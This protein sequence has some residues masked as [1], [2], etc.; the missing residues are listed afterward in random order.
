MSVTFAQARDQILAL[1]T[2]AW[3]AHNDYPLLFDD[4]A[5]EEIPKTSTPWAR[6][7][8]R[9][10]SGEQDTLS[11]PLGNK[12]FSRR[13]VLIVQLFTPRG[14]GLQSADTLAKVF[15]DAYEGKSTSG[16]V[17]FRNARYREIGP[18]GNWYQTNVTL[19]FEYTE[20]K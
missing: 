4:S 5:S 13:G 12:L 17:W 7:T 2:T 9:H 16:G 18:D 15:M 8:I 3:Q 14:K 10:E 6:M 1:G 11:N 19:D 20:L